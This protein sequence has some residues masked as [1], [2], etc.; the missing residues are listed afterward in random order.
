MDNISDKDPKPSSQTTGKPVQFGHDFFNKL[1][2]LYIEVDRFDYNDI[3]EYLLVEFRNELEKLQD[4]KINNYEEILPKIIEKTVI[5]GIVN[6]LNDP[7][8]QSNRGLALKD[9]SDFQRFAMTKAKSLGLTSDELKSLMN[10]AYIYLPYI[11]RI[12][13]LVSGSMT[14]VKVAG[15]IIWYQVV[16]P[17]SGIV[18]IN[19]I[20]LNNDVGEANIDIGK[21]Q[22]E[23]GLYKFNVDE[24]NIDPGPDGVLCTDDDFII[25][26]SNLEYEFFTY[27]V[28]VGADG[29]GMQ[30]GRIETELGC[31]QFWGVKTTPWQYTQYPALE[32]FS[33]NLGVH[34]KAI[35]AFKLRAQINEVDG[36]KFSF[37]LGF[38]EGV[39]LD[40]E[41]FLAQV[42]EDEYGQEVFN[43]IGYARVIKTGN[44]RK[45]P[46]DF[47]RAKKLWGSR[48]SDGDVVLENPN[49]GIYTGW[50]VSYIQNLNILKN[51]TY[52]YT[53]DI[54]DFLENNPD[55]KDY[56][57]SELYEAWD[58]D[59]GY[60]R[61]VPAF[62]QDI[63][64]GIGIYWT[65][66]EKIAP[67]TGRS[68]TFI[69]SSIGIVLPLAQSSK[70][71]T[72]FMNFIIPFDMFVMGRNFGGRYNLGITGGIGLDMYFLSGLNIKHLPDSLSSD[73]ESINTH[74]YLLNRF[75]IPI[76]FEANSSFMLT[77][78]IHISL[79][80]AY[81]YGIDP[82]L[83]RWLGFYSYDFVPVITTHQ[84]IKYPNFIDYEAINLGGISINIGISFLKKTSK[85]NIGQFEGTRKF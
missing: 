18:S 15:G 8:I 79:S 44:N 84:R 39:N 31:F 55:Y 4:D 43:R 33:R 63:T 74:S 6:I 72:N 7:E 81:R 67:Q 32:A 85:M 20:S 50:K 41:F 54:F 52:L 35:D 75:E 11:T 78:D 66:K 71:V 29:K 56:T 9:E 30:N 42:E 49:R 80:C 73:D 24:D 68:Q 69:K 37:P 14:T 5:N 38:K 21:Y 77:P 22:L 28:G 26:T 70:Y 48:I 36:R 17:P 13:E 19:K 58:E 45:D 83:V 25:E 3:P 76:F 62:S 12:E 40:D 16:I 59:A 64:K 57:V 1:T 65:M 51:S 60:T 47:T 46:T 27:M 53:P 2:E 61:P 10:S 23:S 82:L 34:T